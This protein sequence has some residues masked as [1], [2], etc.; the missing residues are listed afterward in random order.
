MQWPST[1]AP[2]VPLPGPTLVHACLGPFAL[3]FPRIAFLSAWLQP[4]VLPHSSHSTV[5]MHLSSAGGIV[6]CLV[7][8][9]CSVTRG[10]VGAVVT[11]DTLCYMG[12]S[13]RRRWRYGGLPHVF[14]RIFTLHIVRQKESTGICACVCPAPRQPLHAGQGCCT[15]AGIA[16]TVHCHIG[17]Q[18]CVANSAQSLRQQAVSPVAI[19]EG[20][21]SHTTLLWHK[22]GT[23]SGGPGV[24]TCMSDAWRSRVHA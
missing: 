13:G 2:E 1:A 7:T 9:C 15:A 3:H 16:C 4:I 17:C 20:R 6:P 23:H 11:G 5:C 14:I 12:A 22:L 18:E 19:Q 21:H 10:C 24:D 8:R